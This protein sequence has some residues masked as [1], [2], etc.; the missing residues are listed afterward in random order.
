MTE[1]GGCRI[2]RRRRG[3]RRRAA[4]RSAPRVSRVQAHCPRDRV[5]ASARKRAACGLRRLRGRAPGGALEGVD[6]AARSRDQAAGGAGGKG[7]RERRHRS[8]LRAHPGQQQ[9][10]GGHQLAQSRQLLGHRRA[11]DRADVGDPG[12]PDA[13]GTQRGDQRGEP[14]TDASAAGQRLVLDLRR[15]G[16]G[17]PHQH[18][19]P[20]ADRARRGEER[21]HRVTPEQRAD[22]QRVGAEAREGAKRR[23]QPAEESLPVGSGTDI[24]VAPLGVRDHEQAVFTR[25][26]DQARERSPA[27]RPE[28]LET[29]DLELDRHAF[30]RPRPRA[31]SRQW[32]ADRGRGELRRVRAVARRDSGSSAGNAIASGHSRFGSG[33]NPRTIWE[34]RRSTCSASRSP[35]PVTEATGRAAP[36][37][38]DPG[39]TTRARS[40][41]GE[42]GAAT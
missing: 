32:R 7:R 9:R 29:G 16:I 31:R 24:D 10:G 21:L 22:G 37:P 12:R 5:Q 23:R 6:D 39:A 20:A 18:E 28:P 26:V 19:Q 13:I 15:A 35:K 8:S 17:G 36:A 25:V 3:L 40:R 4:H 1:T 11:D 41:C 14:V 42:T 33:S 34:R 30:A 38:G 27:G 2:D